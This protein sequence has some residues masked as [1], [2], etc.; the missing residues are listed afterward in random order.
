ML[1]RLRHEMCPSPPPA[2]SSYPPC[3]TCGQAGAYRWPGA[4]QPPGSHTAGPEACPAASHATHRPC[5]WT[6]GPVAPRPSAAPPAN[7]P[8]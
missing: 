8:R 2:S 1:H 5:G 3:Q 6:A 7:P 4:R